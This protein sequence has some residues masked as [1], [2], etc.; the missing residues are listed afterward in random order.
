MW[1]LLGNPVRINLVTFEVTFS[2]E[3]QNIIKAVK[4][5]EHEGIW[6]RINWMHTEEGDYPKKITL[7]FDNVSLKK[8]ASI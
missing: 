3:R 6:Y 2:G 5:L 8:Y 7:Q 1:H 4:L